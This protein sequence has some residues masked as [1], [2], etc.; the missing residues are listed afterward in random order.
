MGQAA[1][2]VVRPADME[3]PPNLGRLRSY[4]RLAVEA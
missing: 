4:P 3:K 2:V 1:L